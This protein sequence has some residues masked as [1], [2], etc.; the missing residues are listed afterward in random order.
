MKKFRD[1]LT[2]KIHFAREHGNS[3][4]TH[5]PA[6]SHRDAYTAQKTFKAKNRAQAYKKAEKMA[7][8]GELHFE[9]YELETIEIEE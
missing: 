2:K 5:M 6:R 7:E 4:T 3:S 1:P 9:Y 8:K